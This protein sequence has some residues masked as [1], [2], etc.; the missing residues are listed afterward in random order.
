MS[1]VEK[2][3]E[4]VAV[5][6]RSR[7]D[8]TENQWWQRVR[9]RADPEDYRPVKWPPPGPYWCSGHGWGDPMFDEHGQ[10]EYSIVV[11]YVKKREQVEE[12]WPE[13]THVEM[14][15]ATVPLNFTDRFPQ[16]H[17]W[18]IEQST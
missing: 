7:K 9:F 15:E 6:D 13:A 4:H 11:A 10:T 12:F 1:E 8:G 5:V 17:W 2:F 18:P 16:P 3:R 14:L